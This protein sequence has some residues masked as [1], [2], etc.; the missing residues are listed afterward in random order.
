MSGFPRYGNDL[1]IQESTLEKLLELGHLWDIIAPGH[2]H[3]RAYLE[4]DRVGGVDVGERKSLE[5]D[6]ALSELQ[7]Y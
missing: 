1:H 6:D 5:M 2:G 7:S 3:T 4:I